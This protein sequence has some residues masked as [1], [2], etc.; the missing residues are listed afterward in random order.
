M[1]AW[2]LAPCTE[3]LVNFSV[4]LSPLPLAVCKVHEPLLQWWTSTLKALESS[5]GRYGLAA[6][7]VKTMLS[8]MSNDIQFTIAKH[9]GHGHD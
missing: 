6:A 8:E 4:L 7:R 3:P 2:A 5:V 9:R 1:L